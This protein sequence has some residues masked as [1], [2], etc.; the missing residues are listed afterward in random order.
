MST[1]MNPVDWANQL[2]ATR[3]GQA[4]QDRADGLDTYAKQQAA[5]V[6]GQ[7]SVTLPALKQTDYPAGVSEEWQLEAEEAYYTAEKH[8]PASFPD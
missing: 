6:Y 4:L 7:D 1:T 8:L 3:L 2:A 5:L